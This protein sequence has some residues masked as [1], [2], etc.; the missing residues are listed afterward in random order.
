MLTKLDSFDAV[1]ATWSNPTEM[2]EALG[3]P[4][5]TA[6]VMRH[7]RSISDL[8]WPKVITC[9]RERGVEL[10]TDDL[11]EMKHKRRAEAKKVA[12]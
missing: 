6:Q 12:A 11:L 1:L 5:V 10:T 4:Y 7:R 2:S 9:L 8:H 3:I